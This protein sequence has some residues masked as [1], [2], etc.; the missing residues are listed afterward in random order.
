MAC[1]SITP[2]RLIQSLYADFSLDLNVDESTNGG[3]ILGATGSPLLA[4]VLRD[5][6]RMI[7]SPINETKTVYDDWLSDQQRNDP[8]RSAPVLDLMG[9]GS[10]YTVFFDHLGI[11]SVDLLFNRQG[12]GVY[13][14]H[15]NYDSYYW[16]DK[17][18][19]VGFKKHLAMAQLWGLL[20]VRLAGV[21]NIAFEASEYPK[22]LAHHSELL[23]AKYGKVLDFSG[24]NQAIGQ[25]EKAA[26]SLD[27]RSPIK[28]S[29]TVLQPDVEINRAYLNLE[30][31]FL[32]PKGAGLPGREWYRH[33]V[34]PLILHSV[35]CII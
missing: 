12:K 11:P 21:S 28:K 9:T 19:D 6:T 8:G 14:Y 25:F 18:G 17:F 23:Q 13:P 15:S 10:D 32:L 20:T 29:P 34:S 35:W 30:R 2:N 1:E 31:Q 7:K 27:L 24:L 26:S 3:T 4:S 22:V 16:V 33:V 5:V